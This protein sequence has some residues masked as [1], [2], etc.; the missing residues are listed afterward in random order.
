VAITILDVAKHRGVKEVD[1][2]INGREFHRVGLQF[3]GGCERCGATL[4]AYNAYPDKSGY[5]RC[6]DCLS[7]PYETVEEF[8]ADVR[9][10][11]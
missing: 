8:E 3:L 7:N 10:D 1:G 4:A 5:W 11:R 6:A 2:V 9:S